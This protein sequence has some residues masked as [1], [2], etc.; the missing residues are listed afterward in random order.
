M[1]W[2]FCKVGP[3]YVQTLLPKA[4]H[5]TPPGY[6]WKMEREQVPMEIE[7]TSLSVQRE[8][9]KNAQQ[10]EIPGVDLVWTVRRRCDQV[11]KVDI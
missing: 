4:A 11:L 7:T 8:E 2:S 9:E 10:S 6:S 5:L 1:Y 3:T